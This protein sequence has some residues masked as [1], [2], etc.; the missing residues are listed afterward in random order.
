LLLLG[1]SDELIN[2][3]FYSNSKT[4]FSDIRDG[5][6][7]TIMIGEKSN[8]TFD[9][10]WAG[11]S[12][13]TEHTGWRVVAWAGE[14]PNNP[15]NSLVHFHLYAQ[16][17]SMHNGVTTFAFCDG[18]VRV[19]SDNVE[20]DLFQALGTVRGRERISVGDL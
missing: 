11:I 8:E 1:V 10:T 12:T 18:S 4:R 14:P 6:S 13:G 20:A 3:V 9:N 19:I 16:Y 2:G 17:N 5:V 15:E 7:N